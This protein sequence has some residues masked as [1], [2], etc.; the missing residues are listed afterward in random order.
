MDIVRFFFTRIREGGEFWSENFNSRDKMLDGY[1]RKFGGKGGAWND[2]YE[3][4]L[5]DREK[6]WTRE[7]RIILI[8]QR[9]HPSN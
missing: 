4:C 3:M 1:S 5:W 6:I 7:T 9:F 8:T 2:G